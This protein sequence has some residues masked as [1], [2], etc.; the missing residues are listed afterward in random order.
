MSNGINLMKTPL[1]IHRELISPVLI[2]V[3]RN[4]CPSKALRA[5]IY[6]R[7]NLVL[8]RD[9]ASDL[10]SAFRSIIKFHLYRV[11]RILVSAALPVVPPESHHHDTVARTTIIN[12]RP[13]GMERA[14]MGIIDREKENERNVK[15]GSKSIWAGEKERGWMEGGRKS[16]TWYPET[17]TIF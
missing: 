17:I 6:I 9:R 11:C 14:R 13:I 8:S 7:A 2:G 4:R 16:Y 12:S 15:P 5:P 1:Q 10:P 3:S